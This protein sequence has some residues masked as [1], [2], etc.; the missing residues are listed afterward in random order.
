[1]SDRMHNDLVAPHFKDRS[2]SLPASQAVQHLSG[3][4]GQ[5]SLSGASGH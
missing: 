1:M 3:N 2:M 5:N 4:E